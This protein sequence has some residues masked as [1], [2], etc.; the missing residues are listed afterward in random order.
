[1]QSAAAVQDALLSLGRKRQPLHRAY[2]LLF[3]PNLYRQFATVDT[4]L[5]LP[6]LIEALRA[7][8]F[9]GA[10]MRFRIGPWPKFWPASSA[11]G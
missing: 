10:A 4:R 1:M 3:N 11:S 9:A 6:S 2:R 5:A 7:K 8:R